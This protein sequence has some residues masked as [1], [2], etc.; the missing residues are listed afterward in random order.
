MAKPKAL[1]LTGY[2][3]NCDEETR[4]SFEMAGADATVIHINDIIKSGITS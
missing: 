2:G 3:I 1:I 4:F